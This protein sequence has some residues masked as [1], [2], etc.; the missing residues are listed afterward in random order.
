MTILNDGLDDQYRSIEMAS[1]SSKKVEVSDERGKAIDLAMGAIEKQF[2]DGAIMPLGADQQKPIEGIS[3]GSLSL[4]MAL[5]GFGM[6][7][8]IQ[9][10]GNLCEKLVRVWR[11]E[12][13]DA[14]S[15]VMPF[16]RPLA[17]ALIGRLSQAWKPD[18]DTPSTSHI[19]LTGQIC[20]CFA[21]NAA[22]YA[23]STPTR[24]HANGT[25]V[26]VSAQAVPAVNRDLDRQVVVDQSAVPVE[27]FHVHNGRYDAPDPLGAMAV[28]DEDERA[29]FLRRY[30][31]AMREAYP[32]RADGRTLLPFRRLFIVA[33]RK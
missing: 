4:D 25:S 8:G 2:G 12:A 3:T 31:V 9:D 28:L 21:T 22:A 20:R 11:D 24:R 17:R 33:V 18:R 23:G 32:R 6:N 13:D 10:A 7:S 15:D 16:A 19:Q 14:L 30:T 26:P 5:G 27:P 1:K 29:A